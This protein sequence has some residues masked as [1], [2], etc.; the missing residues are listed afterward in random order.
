MLR[1]YNTR[2][3]QVKSFQS[4]LGKDQYDMATKIS[5]DVYDKFYC[6]LGKIMLFSSRKILINHAVII[7]VFYRF[8]KQK[9]QFEKQ[10][11]HFQEAR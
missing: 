11:E 7:A 4:E 3:Q 8:L 10:S 2:K 5:P 1:S 9:N 6:F